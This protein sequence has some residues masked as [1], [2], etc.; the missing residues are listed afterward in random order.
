MSH[1]MGAVP[2]Y[3][4]LSDK[5]VLF[6]GDGDGDGM[7]MMFGLF[8]TQG[9]TSKPKSLTVLDFD[10]RMVNNIDKFSKDFEFSV[11]VKA[12]VYNVIDK[13]DP[14][15]KQK[16]DFFYINPPYGSKNKGLS[17]IA[18]LHRCMELCKQESSGCL[19]IPYD[20]NALWTVE[21]MRNIQD[22]LIKLLE[23]MKEEF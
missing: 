9:L 19:V 23:V 20:E 13:V 1:V 12:S 21:A 10:E 5:D 3:S 8:A 4:F 15:L 18:W 11:P 6:L 17:T 2:M 16:F 7:S 14:D 22:F